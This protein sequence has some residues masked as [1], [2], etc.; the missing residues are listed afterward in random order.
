MS[1]Q[2]RYAEKIVRVYFDRM[3]N[4]IG[5]E[6]IPAELKRCISY[7]DKSRLVRE[8]TM[9][10][11]EPRIIKGL[12]TDLKRDGFVLRASVPKNKKIEDIVLKIIEHEYSTWTISGVKY[13]LL[14][15]GCE[16]ANLD[17]T[18]PKGDGRRYQIMDMAFFTEEEVLRRI[19]VLKFNGR[20][21]GGSS[22]AYGKLDYAYKTP[23]LL[24][25]LC[26]QY[27]HDR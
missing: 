8:L 15:Y 10:D 11:N 4:S 21:M 5:S 20:N 16:G 9:L 19:N 17:L 2:Q 23:N 1:L 7:G 27:H 6:E 22:F 24:A 26:F 18:W 12:A 25:V 13:N 3:G 14:E